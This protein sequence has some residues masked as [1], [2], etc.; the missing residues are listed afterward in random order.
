MFCAPDSFS[1][2]PWA[3][4]TVFIFC[5]PG[6]VFNGPEGVKYLFHVLCSQTHLGRYR[7]LVP[8]LYFAHPDSFSTVQSASSPVFMFCATG[9]LLYGTEGL[10]S[11][12]NFLRSRTRFGRYRERW[13][14]F[15]YFALPNSFSTIP[16]ASGPVFMF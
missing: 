7:R 14:A 15:T 4:G 8:F 12:F 6:L 1:T 3:S 2:V 10:R 13:V 9:L 16:R 5:A 11:R